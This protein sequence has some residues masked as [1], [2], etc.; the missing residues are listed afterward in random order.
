MKNI[1]FKKFKMENEI[2]QIK[3][4]ILKNKRESIEENNRNSLASADIETKS[5][6][7]KKRLYECSLREIKRK[8]LTNLNDKNSLPEHKLSNILS[9]SR[10]L[11]NNTY[12]PS[13]II[14]YMKKP[15]SSK[16]RLLS[17]LNNLDKE[18][19]NSFESD[20]NIMITLDL[21]YTDKKHNGIHFPM[22]RPPDKDTL[23]NYS[24]QNCDK[25]VNSIYEKISTLKKN[26]IKDNPN[27]KI[28]ETKFIENLDLIFP[29]ITRE[30]SQL[31]KSSLL[32]KNKIQNYFVNISK[33][34]LEKFEKNYSGYFSIISKNISY[35]KAKDKSK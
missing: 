1:I 35:N 8:Q 7:L 34:I 4:F 18:Y 26:I 2:N 11:E 28:N 3:N 21:D 27:L 25:I 15:K 14:S 17:D 13:E 22:Y 5:K 20:K 23:K 12:T 9:F 19:L 33:I 29:F 16:N 10:T 30:I 24:T 6:N 31:L 32:V